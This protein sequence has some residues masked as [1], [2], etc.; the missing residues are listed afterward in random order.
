MFPFNI[1]VTAGFLAMILGGIV[2]RLLWFPLGRELCIRLALF[3]MLGV[4]VVRMYKR[5]QKPD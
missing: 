1:E 5:L 3:F 2:M 4:C